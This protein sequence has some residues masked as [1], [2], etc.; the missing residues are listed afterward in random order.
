MLL[1]FRADGSRERMTVELDKH[2]NL[3]LFTASNADQAE[4]STVDLNMCIT[5]ESNQNL[6]EAEKFVMIHAILGH[7]GFASIRCL[8]KRGAFGCGHL[9]TKAAECITAR[10][11]PLKC[12]SCEYGK[13]RRRSTG[14]TFAKE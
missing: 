10:T 2:Y 4:Q 7:H 9:Q 1:D 14:S 5:M 6:T 12:A 11:T 8:L 3:P 13:G